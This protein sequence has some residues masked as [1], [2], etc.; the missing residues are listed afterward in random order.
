MESPSTASFVSQST[1]VAAVSNDKYA[2]TS[3]DYSK[4]VVMSPPPYEDMPSPSVYEYNR[5]QSV[6]SH[7]DDVS[8]PR[9]DSYLWKA[10]KFG[11]ASQPRA[12][13]PLTHAVNGIVLFSKKDALTGTYAIDP[14]LPRLNASKDS[15]AIAAEREY[16]HEV[17]RAENG[18]SWDWGARKPEHETHSAAFRTRRGNIDLNLAIA[19]TVNTNV[20]SKRGDRVPAA[21]SISS[22]HGDIAVNVTET[23]P[24][25]V[26]HL[27][28]GSRT[29]NILVL[30]PPS[31]AGHVKLYSRHLENYTNALLPNLTPRCHLVHKAERV[32]TLKVCRPEQNVDGR[33]AADSG[34]DLCIISTRTGRI[35]IGL[36]GLDEIDADRIWGETTFHRIGKVVQVALLGG[37]SL[38]P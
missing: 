3:R 25:R 37:T 12:H 26:L 23:Q 7:A 22:R 6:S 14:A 1:A 11:D 8:R 4:E 38:L 35:A 36:S 5:D 30:L 17:R 19:A 31:F 20:H 9:L 33:E 21:V 32:I 27:D 34:D 2:Y 16:A 28:V 29:G 18:W 10:A 15:D 24:G 13:R